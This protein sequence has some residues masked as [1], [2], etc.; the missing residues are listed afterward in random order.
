M[1]L[2]K[3]REFNRLWGNIVLMK[4]QV[5]ELFK[6]VE[7]SEILA[8]MEKDIAYIIEKCPDVESVGITRNDSGD[9]TDG[10]SI[11]TKE[12][13]TENQARF[14]R[15]L[16]GRLQIIINIR[17]LYSSTPLDTNYIRSFRMINLDRNPQGWVCGHAYYSGG[18]FEV[19]LGGYFSHLFDAIVAKDLP[20]FFDT[21]MRFVKNPNERDSWG[22]K[23][24]LFP[25]VRS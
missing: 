1:Y 16:V 7:K 9:P 5:D 2:S 24:Q 12:I 4:R 25:E 15:R 14:G 10:I 19:C 21:L 23:I 8:K 3:A 18:S 6:I 13:I 17:Y 22:S 20:L 11:I